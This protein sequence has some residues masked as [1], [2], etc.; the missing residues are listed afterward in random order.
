LRSRYYNPAVGRFGVADQLDGIP[1]DPLSLH[2][3]TYTHNNPVN[4]IDPSGN[5]T[6]VELSFAMS[7]GTG[8]QLGYEAGMGYIEHKLQEEG[9]A[10]GESIE[11][12]EEQDASP[13]KD[14]ATIIVHGVEGVDIGG[15][16]TN[17]WSKPFQNNLRLNNGLNHDFYEFDWGGFGLGPGLGFVPVKSVHQM[18]FIHLQ[19]A[20]M[21]IWMK[22]YDKIN[23]ISHSWG[24]CLAY[25]LLNSGGIE[26]SD[27]VTMGSPL[28]HGITKPV[29]NTGKWINFYSTRDP[30]THFDMYPQPF[31]PPQ[32]S[33]DAFNPPQVDDYK[34][35]TTPGSG[36]PLSEHTAYWSYKLKPLVIDTI[37]ED[38]QH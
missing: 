14:T 2:K 10:A 4:N 32:W 17:G 30:V 27:W 24:T 34:D 13:D 16:H 20:Q 11:Q 26:M 25:D 28:N 19:T 23:V 3:Y 15:G 18:A 36:Y 21:L 7:I 31:L 33:D 5:E 1:T 12:I 29:W 35:V 6:M 38:L 37:R 9:L 8:L 22:G